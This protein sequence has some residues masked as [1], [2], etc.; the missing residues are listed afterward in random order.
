VLTLAS[1]G[2]TSA[3]A[4]AAEALPDVLTDVVVTVADELELVR[5]VESDT[6]PEP[7]PDAAVMG[8]AD[9]LSLDAD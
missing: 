6:D 2:V 9:E 4:F 8:A 3:G 1:T 7:D 5:E